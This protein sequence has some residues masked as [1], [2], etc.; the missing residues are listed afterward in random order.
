[1]D[2]VPIL[3]SRYATKAY[4]AQRSIEPAVIE[5]IKALLRYAPSSTNA[6]PWHFF[7]AGTDEGKVKVARSTDGAYAFNRDKV[8][9]ASHVVVFCTRTQMDEAH[10][11]RVLAQETEDGRLTSDESRAGQH[12]GR[13]FFVNMHRYEL[14]DAQHWMD[15]QVYLAAGTLLLG[16]GA[17]GVDATPIEGFD[18]AV[19]NQTLGLHEKGLTATLIVSLG[20]RA[21]D[22]FNRKLPKS[23]L[24]LEAVLTEI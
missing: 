18:A 6:Q 21:E 3:H 2:L 14:K 4:D 9:R 15:K 10:L 11:Q 22:D 13:S 23:R 16:A 19:L 17:L 1:M 12:K 5:Q 7:L 24:P 8:L 20:Y